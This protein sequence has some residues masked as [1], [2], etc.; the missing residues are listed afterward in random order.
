[1]EHKLELIFQ[2]ETVSGLLVNVTDEPLT[3]K[4][5]VSEGSEVMISYDQIWNASIKE[6]LFLM[7]NFK[8]TAFINTNSN[9][10]HV[11]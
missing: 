11:F 4:R 5:G 10:R 7:N 1:M 2:V 6:I 9:P 8:T 3:H